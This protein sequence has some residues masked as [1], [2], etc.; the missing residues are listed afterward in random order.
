[1]II[2]FIFC[3]LLLFLFSNSYKFVRSFQEEEEEE[4]EVPIRLPH[5]CLRY[6]SSN[7]C[8]API[9][10]YSSQTSSSLRVVIYVPHTTMCPRTTRNVSSYYYICVHTSDVLCDLVFTYYFTPLEVLF[11]TLNTILNTYLKQYI[12]QVLPSAA[13]K[14]PK[15]DHTLSNS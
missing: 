13:T 12:K 8:V 11:V 5:G 4:E 2:F 9:V 15:Q 6:N 1:M 3:S 7:Y 14:I 10:C